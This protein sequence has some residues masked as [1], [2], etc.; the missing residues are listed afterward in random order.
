MQ[1]QDSNLRPLGYEPNELPNC[2]HSA[3]KKEPVFHSSRNIQT[4]SPKD[5]AVQPYNDFHTLSSLHSAFRLYFLASPVLFL[6][7]LSCPR[8]YLKFYDLRTRQFGQL[9]L[10]PYYATY[11]FS[12]LPCFAN[13]LTEPTHQLRWF[14]PSQGSETPKIQTS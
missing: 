7:D 4:T 11:S 8:L 3:I 6:S 13:I 12:K 10:F 14:Q 9:W 5:I 1:R 2:F